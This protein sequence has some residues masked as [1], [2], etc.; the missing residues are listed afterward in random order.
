MSTE[1]LKR[2]HEEYRKAVE[3]ARNPE[4]DEMAK[5]AGD[6]LV[7]KR[8]ALDAAL[9]EA[10]QAREDE[11][12]IAAEE[13]RERAA[14]KVAGITAA[15]RNTS[16]LPVDE[17]RA[18]VRGERGA[19]QAV[20]PF[21]SP[22]Q[23]ADMVTS[24]STVY[25][26]YTVP[27]TWADRVVNFQIAGSG[28]LRAGPTIINTAGGNQINMPILSTDASAAAG[29]EGSGATQTNPVFSTAPLNA[30]RF[31]GYFS[32]SNEL[33]EDTGVDM[34]SLLAEYAGRA[35]AAKI[36]PYFADPD[37][38]TGSSTIAAVQIGSTTGKTAAAYT[39]VT[40][41]EIKELIYSVLPEYRKSGRAAIVANSAVTLSTALA[42]D[43]N[44]AYLWQPS[45]IAS[46]PDRFMGYPWHEDAYMDSLAT[47][48]E[49][50]FFGD[51]KSA[52]VV[53][54][55][56]G[57]MKF[58]ASKEFA[59]TSFETTF[60]WGVWVDAVTVDTLAVKS[61]LLP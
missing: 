16:G 46:E 4:S 59:V 33:L 30:Y 24:D 13:A 29:T 1:D 40:V 19:V 55:A 8:A 6:D 42:R 54:Y 28:V 37:V 22:E 38:G 35:L 36:N 45:L 61:L 2:L 49:P 53:R 47:G 44:G 39:G 50:M 60:V 51:L 34:E 58:I 3:A 15:A 9:I 23:R 20:I 7:A 11:A 21:S 48:N 12:R 56:H 43:D 25:A 27:Q 10:E 31:D 41:D 26:Q 17:I 14:A 32:V 5:A 52:Y 18:F 57:G